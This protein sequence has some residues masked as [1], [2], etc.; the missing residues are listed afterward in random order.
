M[1]PPL[2]GPPAKIGSLQFRPIAG[3]PEPDSGPVKEDEPEPEPGNGLSDPGCGYGFCEAGSG[4]GFCEAG[5]GYEP[6]VG[7]GCTNGVALGKAGVG[8]ERFWATVKHCL[9]ETFTCMD[10]NG[11]QPSGVVVTRT[12]PITAKVTTVTVTAATIRCN[13]LPRIMPL[14]PCPCAASC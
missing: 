5:G 12:T 6:P 13:R 8:L 11:P 10:F 7:D 9:D 14:L 1:N 3:G 2:P 4:Y